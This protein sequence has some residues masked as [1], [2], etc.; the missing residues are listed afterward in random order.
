[1]SQHSG[2]CQ[3]GGLVHFLVPNVD[4]W[5]AEFQ[6]GWVSVKEPPNESLD[7]LRDM[8]LVDPDETI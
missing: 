2:D 7:G 3:V 8:T 1:L 5:Y 6:L 4:D